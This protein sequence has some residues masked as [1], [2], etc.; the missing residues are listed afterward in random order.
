MNERIMPHSLEAEKSLIGAMFISKFAKQKALES[1]SKDVFYSDANGIIFDA[2]SKLTDQGT[3]IDATTVTTYLQDNK[4]INRIGGVEYLAD[5]MT[6]VPTSVNIDEYIKIVSE[7]ATL[8]RL[9]EESINIANMG[10]D[11]K[12]QIDEVLNKAEKSILNVVRSKR[13]TEFNKIQDVL[14]KVQSDIEKLSQ[15]NSDITGVSTGFRDIDRLTAGLHPNELII[16]AA[17]PAMGKTAFALN[18]AV[19]ISENSNLPVA[20]FN[21][22]MSAAQLSQR[23][24]ASAG[25]IPINKLTTGKLE[26][27]DW[28]RFNEAI[29]RLSDIKLFID[30]TPGISITDIRSKCRRLSSEEGT[31]GAVV[32][33]YLQLV[34]GGNGFSSS[35]NRQQEVAEV[36][37]SL[38]TLAMELKVPVIALAQLS[39][40]VE[41]REDKRPLM[42]DL[43]ESGQIEQDADIVAFLH[44]DDYYNK[45]ASIDE[46]TSRSEFIVMKHRNGP[47]KTI[48]LIFKRNTSTF[49]NFT[50]EEESR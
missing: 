27:N 38:K 1:L 24:I 44:R 43:R 20:I 37:R 2:I 26:N 50:N 48:D 21:M 32:I 46:F 22:E 4:L 23:M 7:K 33:D 19:N 13:G 39:R 28:K 29:S 41:E 42:S 14:Y 15:S 17:R 40:R 31:L 49:I 10:Y 18:L 5:I 36:S 6:T 11:S 35:F 25:Q 34:S 9:I 12:N 16:I 47:T 30:D 3:I 45:E 8:R